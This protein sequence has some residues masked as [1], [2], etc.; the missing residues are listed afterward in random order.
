MP[1]ISVLRRQRQEDCFKFDSSLVY[2][3]KLQVSQ[4]LRTCV[5]KPNQISQT[6]ASCREKIK[7]QPLLASVH[8]YVYVYS[9][10]ILIYCIMFMYIQLFTWTRYFH[11]QNHLLEQGIQNLQCHRP[12]FLRALPSTLRVPCPPRLI[13][14]EC[15][16][17]DHEAYG[18]H[19]A[20]FYYSTLHA[21][22]ACQQF[23]STLSIWQNLLFS[24][25]PPVDG[26]QQ[27]LVQ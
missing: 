4:V 13:L 18:H 16:L 7:F 2:I 3:A 14:F 1:I 20:W 27:T 26:Y 10:K 11:L 9:S 24:F 15:H 19:H 5:K 21:I 8:K 6:K 22:Y 25:Q 17:K 12:F 23:C